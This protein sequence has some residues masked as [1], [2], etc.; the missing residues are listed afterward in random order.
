MEIYQDRS[1]CLNTAATYQ[2]KIGTIFV[3]FFGEV[4]YAFIS[5]FC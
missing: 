3:V 5:A 2:F 4:R 1:N